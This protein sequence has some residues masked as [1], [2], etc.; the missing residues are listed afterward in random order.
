MRY[1]DTVIASILPTPHRRWFLMFLL[2]AVSAGSGVAYSFWDRQALE[3]DDPLIE[4]GVGTE[5]TVSETWNPEPGTTLVPYGAFL[6][7]HDIDE[8]FF[9]YFVRLNKSGSLTVSLASV[10]INGMED[11]S[12]VVQIAIYGESEPLESVSVYSVDMIPA[13]ESGFYEA[14]IRVRVRL[15]PDASRE[16]Y[17]A[18]QGGS[19][20]MNLQFQ[21]FALIP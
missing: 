16:A 2:L 6:G 20:A 14:T 5:L 19:I 11:A 8:F 18:I 3:V 4:I 15:N 17:L 12:N 10:V 13:T 7:E 21:A 9:T 1:P